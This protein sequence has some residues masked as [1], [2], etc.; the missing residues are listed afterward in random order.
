M[1]TKELLKQKSCFIEKKRKEIRNTKKKIFMKGK[2][3]TDVR[4]RQ[5]RALKITF[6]Y[7]ISSELRFTIFPSLCENAAI[8]S[9]STGAGTSP[10]T[11]KKK[12]L[13]G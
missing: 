11:V 8:F 12:S 13:L 4:I 9:D 5:N 7:Q 6:L 1:N 2:V 10:Q 3:E